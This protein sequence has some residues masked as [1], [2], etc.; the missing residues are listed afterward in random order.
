MSRA[1]SLKGHP[2]FPAICVLRLGWARLEWVSRVG[3]VLCRRGHFIC[4]WDRC[5]FFLFLLPLFMC[6]LFPLLS[7]FPILAFLFVVVL[8][9]VLSSG[10]CLCGV[11]GMSWRRVL[12]AGR[13]GVSLPPTIHN[14]KAPF[15]YTMSLLKGRTST[16]TS[17]VNGSR[18]ASLAQ[19]W[20][21]ALHPID[22]P[23]PIVA[24]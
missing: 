7:F 19:A 12:L 17:S 14:K 1:A 15:L 21:R 11:E 13:Y 16:G 20:G 22:A 4:A 3:W 5:A 9:V 8:L 6:L 24:R 23:R 18:V 2:P 10:C